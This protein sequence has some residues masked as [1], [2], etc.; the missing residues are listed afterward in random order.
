VASLLL[1][2][3]CAGDIDRLL[4]ST[5]AARTAAFRSISTAAQ[6]SA[7]NA[8]SVMFTAMWVAEHRLV[9]LVSG[10]RSSMFCEAVSPATS[11]AG[12]QILSVSI[13]GC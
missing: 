11:R 9:Y 1:W 4:H 6:W 7:A 2:A 3:P 10:E 8:S 13:T 5:S 12:I